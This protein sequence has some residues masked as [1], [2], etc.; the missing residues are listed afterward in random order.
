[1]ERSLEPERLAR[2]APLDAEPA[3]LSVL[4]YNLLAPA[5]VRP[6]DL[7]TGAVQPFA[8]FEWASAEDLEWELRRKRLLKQL[9]SWHADVVCLQEVQFE[10][11]PDGSFALP[12]WLTGLENYTACIPAEKYLTLI[13][14]RNERV[15]ANKVAIGCA[16]LF[17][18]D[19]LMQPS[20]AESF[21][22]PNTLVSACLQGCPES[23]LAALGKTAFFSVH[24]DAQSEEKRVDQL[25][26]CLEK[27]RALGTR[28]VLFAG[29]LNTEC[30]PGSCIAAFISDETP[31]EEEM[32]RECA[33]ALRIAGSED[34]DDETPT[35]SKETAGENGEPSSEQLE[36]WRL[37]WQKAARSPA[38]HRVNLSRV[39]TGATRSAYD[40]GKTEG[41]CVTWKLDHILHSPETLQLRQLWTTLEEDEAASTS[42][43]PNGENPSDH[44]PV[45]AVFQ[46]SPPPALDEDARQALLSRLGDLEARHAAELRDLEEELAKL[47]PAAE[48]MPEAGYAKAKS[49]K[50]GDSPEMIAFKQEKRRRQKELKGRQAVDRQEFVR[51]LGDLELDVME[52][53]SCSGDWLETGARGKPKR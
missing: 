32:A 14:E 16:V 35:D 13:A 12:A 29:D 41:P 53:A 3:C 50:K 27:A 38:E 33:S 26:K 49:K 30:R 28:Q 9:E 18:S 2:G 15:L 46:V 42:G 5:F 52:E 1:M 36:Q 8:A 10:A 25:R 21:G 34:G 43:L 20:D 23:P 6:I 7:R 48:A 22:D 31:S 47:E 37:L 17:R 51:V 45:A 4:S 40:H 44:L 39:P 11:S 19:R 24:L